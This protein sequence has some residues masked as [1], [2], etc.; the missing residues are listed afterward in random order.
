M[1]VG[2]IL[3]GLVVGSMLSFLLWNF[4]CLIFG[5]VDTHGFQFSLKGLVIS[6]IFS[7]V[8]LISVVRNAAKYMKKVSLMDLLHATSKGEPIRATSLILGPLGVVLSI[9]GLLL[10]YALP[11]YT[12]IN[13]QVKM[14]GWW[15]VT[16]LLT[17]IGICFIYIYSVGC[18]KRGRNAKKYYDNLILYST[19]K[20]QGKQTVKNMCVLTL[21]IAASLFAVFYP[22]TIDGLPYTDK[23][24]AGTALLERC[25]K[26]TS[27]EP[28]YIGDYRG[29]SM[30]LSFDTSTSVFHVSLKGNLSHMVD[31]GTDVFGNI[32]RLDNAIEGLPK[33]LEVVKDNLE[34]TIKQFE[35]AKVD[36]C[37][38]FNQEEELQTKT[39]RLNEL[40]ALLNVDKR[41][42]EIVGGEPDEGDE[43]PTPK[44]KNRER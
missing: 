14:P 36:V 13:F 37:K 41:E 28:T 2:C 24:K 31:L 43:E 19:M 5:S 32:Q 33:R 16:Y 10:G 11:I 17:V 9:L 3:I 15:G 18:H 29:F 34:E 39:A 44:K 38:P 22:M 8:V 26:M 23:E 35:T 40:N 4:F 12:Y 6:I 20:F 27:P 7:I 21:M 30:D 42:N 1:T 25:K